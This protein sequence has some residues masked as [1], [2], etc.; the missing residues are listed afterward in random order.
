[1]RFS[2][3]HFL[4]GG[5]A[6]A[7]GM[8]AGGKLAGATTAAVAASEGPQSTDPVG[9]VA[10]GKHL[11]V[12][13]IGIGFGMRGGNRQSNLS[14]RG[15]DHAERVVRYA[16]DQGIRFFDN[17]DLYGSHQYVARALRGLPRESYWLSTKV[18]LH[19]GGLPE[20]ERQDADVAVKRFLQECGTDYFDLVQIHCMMRGDWPQTMRRQMDLLEALK[21]QGLIR[22]HGVSCH[23][24][25]AL[26]AAAE[27]DWVD[28]VH[29]RINP[30][31]VKID[32]PP[33][34]VLATLQKVHRGG[35]GVIGMKIIG[36]GAFSQEP[37]KIDQSI[38]FVLGC[39][40]VDVMIVG[41]ETTDDIDDF[42]ARVGRALQQ[43]AA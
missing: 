37:E 6:G 25:S 19:P 9:L 32:G 11:K 12:S 42:K 7:A 28:V 31:K 5:L 4:E 20:P 38:R 14:R 27:C 17:A 1:M 39:G 15:I 21:E 34:E 43:P 3:R 35:K 41:F 30:F 22:A 23:A 2:R 8:L 24:I 26:E 10:L 16:Y 33:E 18:W 36:E 13:R 29:A 40:V